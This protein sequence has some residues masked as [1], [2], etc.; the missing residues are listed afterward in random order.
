LASQN[1]TLSHQEC[2]GP[3]FSNNPAVIGQRGMSEHL[4]GVEKNSPFGYHLVKKINLSQLSSP[5]PKRREMEMPNS[6]KLLLF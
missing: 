1:A 3:Q 4:L 2:L 6:R 5:P